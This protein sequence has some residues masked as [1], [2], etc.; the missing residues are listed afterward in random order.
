MGIGWSIHK[1]G[2]WQ[3]QLNRVHRWHQRLVSSAITGSSDLEDFAFTFFQNCYYLRDW[4]EKTSNT[5]GAD[6]DILFSQSRELQLCRD[7]CNGTKHL[8]IS[9]PS[10]DANFSIAREYDP[11]CE[12]KYRLVVIADD[13]YDLLELADKCRREWESFLSEHAI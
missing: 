7:L 6:L 3:G 5:D 13:K 9:K 2:G 8:T 11:S 1:N 10:I 12:H 4:V